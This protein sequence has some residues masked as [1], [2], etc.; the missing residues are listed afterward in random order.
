MNWP[1]GGIHGSANPLEHAVEIVGAGPSDDVKDVARGAAKLRS[2]TAAHRL[3]LA[4]VNGRNWEQAKAVT[5]G[6]RVNHS[7]HLIID[8]I[9]EAIGVQGAWNA[10]LRVGVAADAGL[11]HDPVIRVPRG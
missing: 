3:D 6:F 9:H 1:C 10:Q 8:A 4:H 5:I 2:E 11:K 7:V